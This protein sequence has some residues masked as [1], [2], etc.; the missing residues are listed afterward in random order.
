MSKVIKK[1][2][3]G[4]RWGGKY[5]D[6]VIVEYSLFKKVKVKFIKTGHEKY[7]NAAAIRNGT[8]KDPYF[9]S[10]SLVGCIGNTTSSVNGKVKHSY[11]TWRGMICRCYEYSKSSQTYFGKVEVCKDW[12]C[13]ENY[14]KW[15]DENRDRKSVV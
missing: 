15:Y 6:L 1:F 14:E 13:F 10:V 12:W 8:V 4:S 2:A 3:V 11:H 5:G 7:T 9:P